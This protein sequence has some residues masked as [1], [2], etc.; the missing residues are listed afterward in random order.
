[1]IVERQRWE[2]KILEIKMGLFSPT[3]AEDA[4]AQAD[5]LGGQGWELVAV[6]QLAAG[7]PTKMY[8]KR[9]R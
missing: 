1:M 9:P 3:K 5:K 4:T 6:Q 2:Y 8:F 7:N